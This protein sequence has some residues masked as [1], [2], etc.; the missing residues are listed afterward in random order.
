[1]A[2]LGVAACS[3]ATHGPSESA[4]C[5]ALDACCS[6]LGG[7]EASSCH[8]TVTGATEAQCS[9]ALSTLAQA[10]GCPGVSYDG[11]VVDSGLPC[12]V[13]GT[14]PGSSSSG[15]SGGGSGSSS[16]SGGSG[17][18]LPECIPSGA[19]PDGTTYETCSETSAS[20][21]CFAAVVFTDGT[22]YPCA[23]CTNCA[24]ASTSAQSYCTMQ[25]V[26]EAGP[27]CTAPPTLH[28]ETVA[29][30]YCPFTTA[31]AI[32]C[33]SAQACCET[34]STVVN[35]STCQ[36]EGTACPVAGSLAWSCNGPVDCVG[37]AAGPVCCGAGTL[38]L[39]PTC[40]FE[41]G[42]GFTGTHCATSCAAGQQTICAATTDPCPSGSECTPFKV[43]GIELGACF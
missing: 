4:A 3:G 40:G 42:T 1:M 23:S 11:G 17:P 36:A 34:P 14:C 13:T 31:G 8:S 10:G 39:D 26:P 21:T 32:H 37:N 33:A 22:T 25:A 28:A 30:V 24:A 19:C 12:T 38:A 43:S 15:S 2:V 9:A 29:G 27:V 35:G 5:S 18:A 6:S 16:S 7:P 20:G 41:R